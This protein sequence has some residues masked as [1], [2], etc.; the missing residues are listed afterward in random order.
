MGGVSRRLS[1]E[2]DASGNRARVAFPDEVRDANGNI[3]LARHFKYEYDGLNRMTRILE[4]GITAI[5]NFFYNA[6][7]ERTGIGGG[8][9]S[10]FSYDGIG[11]IGS[12]SHDMA[13]VKGFGRV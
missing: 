5:A 2:Y 10:S 12:I 1:Y 4:N 9:N 8:F 13:S 3:T 11:R 6:R 7:G